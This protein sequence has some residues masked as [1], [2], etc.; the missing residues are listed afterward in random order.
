MQSVFN[1]ALLAR[2]RRQAE[3]PPGRSGTF[4]IQIADDL[5][6]LARHNGALARS[7]GSDLS[8]A[9]NIQ[10][11]KPNG[12]QY[13]GANLDPDDSRSYDQNTGAGIVGNPFDDPDDDI[14]PDDGVMRQPND[15]AESV[16]PPL[17]PCSWWAA[18]LFNPADALV[19]PEDARLCLRL[20]RA[21][22]CF[23]AGRQAS[24]DGS[25]TR[26]TGQEGQS[27]GRGGS[28]D[29]P[30][31]GDCVQMYEASAP[32]LCN[33]KVEFPKTISQLHDLIESLGPGAWPAFVRCWQSAC[34]IEPPAKEEKHKQKSAYAPNPAA[35]PH[36]KPDQALPLLPGNTPLL[37]EGLRAALEE[38]PE[39]VQAFLLHM[40]KD[41]PAWR[42]AESEGE[43]AEREFLQN[44]GC[45]PGG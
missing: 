42:Y 10:C 21:R 31:A 4:E 26:L 45:W 1:T 37:E 15:L 2:L 24:Q 32:E 20:V 5:E 16:A 34:G 38:M 28:G 23:E 17:P 12:N 35:E 7:Q 40:P 29:A 44:Q 22:S 43:R 13:A 19:D 9:Q 30:R 18:L 8:I 11:S 6:Y 25:P 3:K 33:E 36:G 27:S 41:P 14:D 39:K